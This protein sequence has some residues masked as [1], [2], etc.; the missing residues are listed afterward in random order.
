MSKRLKLLP[1][2]QTTNRSGLLKL[3]VIGGNDTEDVISM[4][5]YCPYTNKWTLCGEIKFPVYIR[6]SRLAVIDETVYVVEENV[7]STTTKNCSKQ[8]L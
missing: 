4:E 6:Y 7:N 5:S 8:K 3:L 2:K 1:A